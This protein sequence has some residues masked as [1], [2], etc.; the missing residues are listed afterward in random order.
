[1]IK[2]NLLLQFISHLFIA[3]VLFPVNDDDISRCV[4]VAA[5]IEQRLQSLKHPMFP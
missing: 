3:I 2:Y 5:A 1:M 4:I